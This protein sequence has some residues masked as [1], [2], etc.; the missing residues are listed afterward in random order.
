MKYNLKFVLRTQKRKDNGL[1]PVVLRIHL[2]HKAG[3]KYG[4]LTTSVWLAENQWDNAK[5]CVLWVKL[6]LIY[7]QIQTPNLLN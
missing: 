4:Y 6:Y 3:T 5:E 1:C 7:T 2:P